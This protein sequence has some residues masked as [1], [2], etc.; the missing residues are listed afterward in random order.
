MDF[1]EG[2]PKSDGF[3]VILVVVDRFTKFAHFIPLR[4][5]FTASQVANAVDKTAF[6][7]HGIPHSIVSDRDKIFTSR[8]WSDLFKVW[9][10]TL[11]MSSAY[12]PQTDGQTERVNQCLEMYL[13]C[14]TQATSTKWNKW[15]H[16]AE[17][18]YNTSFHTALGCSPHKALFGADPHV[19]QVLVLL[20][21]VHQ[22][23]VDLVSERNQ[24]SAF[25]QQQLQRAQ[26]R[27]KHQAD[28]G[29]SERSFAVGD[30]VFLKLQPYTQS[31]VVNRPYPKLAFKFF[32]PFE[33]LEK[34]GQSAYRLQLP[35]SSLIHPVFHV[36]QL[37]AHVPDH[38]P[39]F[40][41]LP[42]PVV[43]DAADV[44]PEEILDRRLVKK[45]NATHVQ[46]LIKWSSL[47]AH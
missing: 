37:K 12:H 17:Y 27:M 19:S 18:W 2:L 6:K 22:S 1:I 40:T 41:S 8:F 16:L 10:T 25:L 3:T 33:I 35:D 4:H 47:P 46:V 5:P 34:I 24:L 36:S 15:L 39:V 30:Y 13:R 9:D 23:V 7:T 43:L 21:S 20:S 31:S 29:R 26:L 28:K 38:T 32:G 44:W 11:S 42:H 14:I 45:C